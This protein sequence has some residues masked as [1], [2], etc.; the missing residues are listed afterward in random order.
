MST[1]FHFHEILLETSRSIHYSSSNSVCFQVCIR[2]EKFLYLSL[3]T[4]QIS[5]HT[6][7]V[8]FSLLFLSTHI[9]Q[10]Q[11]SFSQ[12][13]PTTSFS[14]SASSVHLS[15]Y[16]KYNTNTLSGMNT[17]HSRLLT[18]TTNAAIDVTADHIM[19]SSSCLDHAEVAGQHHCASYALQ[20]RILE[21]ENSTPR[22]Y[23]LSCPQSTHEIGDLHKSLGAILCTE[24]VVVFTFTLK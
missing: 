7:F 15:S 10:F 9:F 20:K 1:Y 12:L 24:F 14:N 16:W 4:R 2:E 22:L 23:Y 21:A 3:K 11:Y 13:H 5:L 17:A 19:W 18:T 8:C 6:F